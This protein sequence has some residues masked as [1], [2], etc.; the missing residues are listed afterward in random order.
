VNGVLQTLP[1][2]TR[3]RKVE[4]A[5]FLGEDWRAGE[6]EKRAVRTLAERPL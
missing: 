5:M 2:L 6:Q 3:R 4:R 1:G